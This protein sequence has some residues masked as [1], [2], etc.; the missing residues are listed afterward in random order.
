MEVSVKIDN[1]HHYDSNNIN[2]IFKK[3]VSWVLSYIRLYC[4]RV[5]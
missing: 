4:S 3:L 1:N 5:L 2:L